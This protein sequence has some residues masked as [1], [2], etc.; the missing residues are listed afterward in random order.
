MRTDYRDAR[1]KD[2][3]TGRIGTDCKNEQRR[4]WEQNTRMNKG[5]GWEQTAR[6]NIHVGEDENRLQE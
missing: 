5:G 3:Q 4:G 2:E 6:M 1:S